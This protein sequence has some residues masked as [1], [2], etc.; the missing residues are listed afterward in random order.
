MVLAVG[1][2][3]NQRKA[4]QNIRIRKETRR[5]LVLEQSS[6]GFQARILKQTNS[7]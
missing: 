1:F 4:L 7:P 6:N 2:W 5:L 3:R